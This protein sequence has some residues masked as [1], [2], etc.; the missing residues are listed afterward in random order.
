MRDTTKEFY[1]ESKES[2]ERA[3]YILKSLDCPSLLNEQW[4]E[5]TLD[6]FIDNYNWDDGLEVPY[7]ILNHPKCELGTA[8]KIF[9]LGE[10]SGMLDKGYQDYELGH[11]VE[12]I[13]YTFQRIVDGNYSSKHIPFKFPLMESSKKCIKE[14]GWP[15][16]F[17]EDIVI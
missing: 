4:D 8:L 16:Y 1:F 5:Y 2:K 14:A 7:F 10:G 15:Q 9:Y 17:V 3:A 13:E 12:F 6:E 11:W